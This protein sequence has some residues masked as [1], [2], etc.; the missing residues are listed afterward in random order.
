MIVS[1]VLRA[2]V[3]L[4]VKPTVHVERALPVCGAPA[5]VTALG[6]VAAP[7]TTLAPGLAVFVLALVETVRLAAVIV[8]AGGLVIPASVSAPEALL[9]RAQVPPLLASVTSTVAPLVVAVVTA[10]AEQ[11][12]YAPVSATVGVAGIENPVEKPI[13]IVSPVLRAP[14]APEVKPIVQVERASPVCGEPVKV[15]ALGAVAAP[16]TTLAHGLR[17]TVFGADGDRH[18]GGGD[19]LSRQRQRYQ[20]A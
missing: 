13:E 12:V 18:V 10:V 3:A 17:V 19:H 4:E 8:C 1:P 16:I 15:T 7:I 6:A 11:F 9:A 2:P 20:R 5:K 14:V